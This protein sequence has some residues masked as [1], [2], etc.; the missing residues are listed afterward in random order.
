MLGPILL[1][2]RARNLHGLASAISE[3][4]S[5]GYDLART[6][7][8]PLCNALLARPQQFLLTTLPLSPFHTL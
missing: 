4:A 1:S 2:K 3:R 7:S 8:S 5:H 6:T